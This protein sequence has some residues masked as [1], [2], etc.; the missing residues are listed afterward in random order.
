MDEEET[1]KLFSY[2]N[3]LY[4]KPSVPPP[5][6]SD[7]IPPIPHQGSKADEGELAGGDPSGSGGLPAV[8]AWNT[9]VDC[10][11]GDPSLDKMPK[12][13]ASSQEVAKPTQGIL[14]PSK[15]P[16][17]DLKYSDDQ[18]TILD[19]QGCPIGSIRLTDIAKSEKSSASGSGTAKRKEPD[20]P[21]PRL[22][23]VQKQVRL[24]GATYCHESALSIHIGASLHDVPERDKDDDYKEDEEEEDDD[25][26]C[27]DIQGETP[28]D[29]DNEGVE[30]DEDDAQFVNINPIPPNIGLGASRLNKMNKSPP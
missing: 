3:P 21:D 2:R 7:P 13:E 14:H 16:R 10:S 27:E 11:Q 15:L 5:K 8:C 28:K 6:V 4:T 1:K 12:Q 29:E 23:P 18:C 17:R 9:P 24:E 26:N 25:D 22:A 30:D 19:P 20:T